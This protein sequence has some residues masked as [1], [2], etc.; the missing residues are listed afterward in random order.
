MLYCFLITL[1]SVVL[2]QLLKFAIQ[3]ILRRYFK[4]A[5]I[6]TEADLKMREVEGN[7]RIVV[8]TVS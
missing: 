2:S 7:D 1:F 6:A 4:L 8:H 5:L 3:S